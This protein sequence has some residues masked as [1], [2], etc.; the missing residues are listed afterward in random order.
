LTHDKW[1]IAALA[2]VLAGKTPEAIFDA[3]HARRWLSARAIEH[4]NEL[5]ETIK[6]YLRPSR[7][8]PRTRQQLERL[9]TAL[10]SSNLINTDSPTLLYK[11]GSR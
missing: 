6:E 5:T 9:A 11:D 7:S 3:L 1:T 10:I 4:P 8:Q 2:T